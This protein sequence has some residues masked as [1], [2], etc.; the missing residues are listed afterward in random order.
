[1]IAVDRT[2]TIAGGGLTICLLLALASSVG[3][4]TGPAL[5]AGAARPEIGF[6]HSTRISGAL[7]GSP[8]G[9]GGIAVQVSAAAYP[10]RSFTPVG[11]ARTAA[12]GSYFLPV[13][14]DRNTQYR[15]DVSGPASA[16]SPVATV[17]VDEAVSEQ[18]RY[19]PTGGAAISIVSRHPRDLRWGGRRVYWYLAGGS[20]A[21]LP[22][23]STSTSSES[24]PGITRLQ[25][26]V[27][28]PVG[29]FH[30]AACFNAPGQAAMGPA[31]A[32]P[33]C[34]PDR[35][36]PVK[37]PPYAGSGVGPPAYPDAASIAAARSYLSGRAGV[38]AF[39]VVDSHGNESGA[40][41]G[42]RFLSASVVKAMLLVAYL[43]HLHGQHR[44][45]SS[46]DKAIL[47][48]MIHV[49]DNNAATAI[50]QRVGDGA[51]R[52]L[53][54]LAGMK[55][56]SVNGFWLTTQITAADQARYF[57]EMDSLIP[58]EFRGY[59]RS[60]LSHI[61]GSQSW[62]IPAAARPR[63]WHVFF[64]GGWLPFSAHLVNQIARL[65]RP[66]ERIAIAVLTEGD[67]SM[68]YGEQTIQGVAER[69]LRGGP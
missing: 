67:P 17:T 38:T 50:W 18:V 7:S 15:A 28:V 59:A 68:T 58:P 62:G 2:R 37:G 56:F 66:H 39:A 36:A 35:F 23:V 54:R 26:T 11:T 46:P 19:P 52:R 16:E 40:H 44:S 49:S 5:T 4:A 12:D 53:A 32:H 60:L 33:A 22:R 65:E 13:S 69:L 31:T 30:F 64:K 63:R 6:T 47:Y 10:Y 41:T 45:L 29:R 24:R 61:T 48:S 57:Y 55:R 3:A 25:T 43:R 34:N 14:P 21:S 8:G 27:P 42:R 1:M 20:A 9:D 51:L